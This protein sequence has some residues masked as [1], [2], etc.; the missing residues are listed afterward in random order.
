MGT[1]KS[2]SDI[3]HSMV[4]NWGNLSSS[5]TSNCDSSTLPAHKLNSIM[6]NFVSTLGSAA[7][8]GRGGS[9]VGGRSSIRTAKKLGEYFQNSSVQETTSEKRLNLQNYLILTTKLLATSSI[10]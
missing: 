2:F 3:K 5:L 7:V 6:G 1:S 9:R 8:G 4:P 10:T